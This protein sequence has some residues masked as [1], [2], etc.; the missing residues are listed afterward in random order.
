[1]PLFGALKISSS[2]YPLNDIL[3]MVSSD[4]SLI[5]AG[6]ILKLKHPMTFFFELFSNKYSFYDDRTA[7][8]VYLLTNLRSI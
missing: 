6:K 5:Y 7:Y 2:H 4:F 8:L 3:I 1:M